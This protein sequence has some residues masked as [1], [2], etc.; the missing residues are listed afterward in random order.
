[1][2]FDLMDLIST[3]THLLDHGD[4]GTVKLG[5]WVR[6]GQL[7]DHT[8]SFFQHHMV[9]DFHNLSGNELLSLPTSSIHILDLGI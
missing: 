9:G 6:E 8:P 3:K 4:H 5:C 1:M 7:V 2:D